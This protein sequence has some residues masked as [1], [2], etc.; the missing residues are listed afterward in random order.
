MSLAHIFLGQP[1]DRLHLLNGDQV[2]L[3]NFSAYDEY[4]RRQQKIFNE[5]SASAV[6]PYDEGS[7]GKVVD[8]IRQHKQRDGAV[9][10]IS[11]L[12]GNGDNIAC[13]ATLNLAV[14]LML[15][16]EISSLEKSFGFMHHTGQC[17]LPQWTKSDLKSLAGGLFSISPQIDCSRVS[18]PTTFD[19]WSLENVAG[20]KI[21]FTDNLADHLRLANND[22]QLYV[23]HHVAYLEHQ[24][25]M[26]VFLKPPLATFP[27][28]L[29][30]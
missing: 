8:E 6:S 29:T 30:Q 3:L 21:E 2:P 18:I 12:T 4:V 28:P 16:V 11:K 9:S 26:L 24:R 10:C 5:M 20:I 7:L 14:R 1:P 27:G 17:P 22:T 19:A 23:F 13:Q 25:H 15:M